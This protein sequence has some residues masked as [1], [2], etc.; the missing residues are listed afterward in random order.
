MSVDFSPSDFLKDF[1]YR[2]K[3]KKFFRTHIFLDTFAFCL[4]IQGKFDENKGY[5]TLGGDCNFFMNLTTYKNLMKLFSM[6]RGD[7]IITTAVVGESLRH[8]F[9]A[10]EK[11]YGADDNLKEIEDE[12]VDFLQNEIG[13]FK[14]KHP[15]IQDILTHRWTEEIKH[16]KL[17]D[18]IEIGEL[19]LFVESDKCGYNAIITNDAYKRYK[20]GE[21]IKLE[22]TVVVQLNILS[23]A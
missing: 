15:L 14:E 13:L 12:F 10:I 5:D 18:R 20:S 6:C 3:Y 11:R 4:I 9:K 19:S 21:C 2:E 16:H 23:V 17:K 1:R 22:D 7:L 8:M